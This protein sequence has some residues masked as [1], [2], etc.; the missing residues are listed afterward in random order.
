MK[1]GDLV[2]ILNLFHHS[3]ER[4]HESL[5][6]FDDIKESREKE[7][8]FDAICKRFEVAFEQAWKA[9]QGVVQSVGGEAMSPKQAIQEAVHFGWTDNPEFWDAALVARN[10]SVHNYFSVNEKNF[11]DTVREFIPQGHS[12]LEKLRKAT[13]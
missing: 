13:T 10:G 2:S 8:H 5:Q 3:L 7:I 6:S 9:M 1:K 11:L 4:L 12:L